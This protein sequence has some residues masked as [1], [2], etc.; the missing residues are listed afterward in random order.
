VADHKEVTKTWLEMLK[1]EA[2]LIQAATDEEGWQAY[3]DQFEAYQSTEFDFLSKLRE[4]SFFV[5]S[6][7]FKG[8]VI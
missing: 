8:N 6:D 5:M 2:E 3:Y 1:S 4:V 7:Y